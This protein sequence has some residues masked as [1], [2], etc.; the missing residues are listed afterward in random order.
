MLYKTN[1]THKQQQT[2]ISI[3]DR[4]MKKRQKIGHT[5]PRKTTNYAA[6]DPRNSYITE[7]TKKLL[8]RKS[9]TATS[10]LNY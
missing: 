8:R 6:I 2:I 4:K 7:D 5:T 3:R 1:K 9:G 10:S